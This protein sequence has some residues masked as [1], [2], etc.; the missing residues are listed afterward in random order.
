MKWE[1]DIRMLLGSAWAKKCNERFAVGDFCLL[2]FTWHWTLRKLYSDGFNWFIKFH[3]GCSAPLCG[4][5]C[6]VWSSLV[7]FY[8]KIC[9]LFYWNKLRLRQPS[10]F[11]RAFLI[12]C[13]VMLMLC[14]A[15]FY[16]PR[17]AHRSPIYSHT[18]VIKKTW[19]TLARAIRYF[20]DFVVSCIRQPFIYRAE[21]FS[22][23]HSSLYLADM[24]LLI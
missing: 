9:C 21:D 17:E 7:K 2:L 10:Y 12:T 3:L 13:S 6:F 22:L 20:V 23:Q 24:V 15:L 5:S 18:Y 11:V 8:R 14:S 1:I 16:D 4:T 19:R